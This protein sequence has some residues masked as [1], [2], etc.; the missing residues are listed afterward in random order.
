M[1]CCSRCCQSDSLVPFRSDQAS[2]ASRW[3]KR[4]HGKFVLEGCRFT[5]LD[6]RQ[7]KGWARLLYW[8]HH[9]LAQGSSHDEV[10]LSPQRGLFR[11]SRILMVFWLLQFVVC[12]VAVVEATDG[13]MIGYTHHPLYNMR[14]SCSR[15]APEP[16][17]YR[18]LWS[19]LQ[20]KMGS[21]SIATKQFQLL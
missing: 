18:I 11:L 16:G 1:R 14:W 2:D 19:L 15:S 21:T 17:L 3:S 8:Y 6:G 7:G 12:D 10:S 13:D 4:R 9:W 20:I 5:D